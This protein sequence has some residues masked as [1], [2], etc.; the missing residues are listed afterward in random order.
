MELEGVFPAWVLW[1]IAVTTVAGASTFVIQF[2]VHQIKDSWGNGNG[3][4]NDRVI[5]NGGFVC[6]VDTGH[7]TG[8]LSECH[9]H[10]EA[11]AERDARMLSM[12]DQIIQ[13]LRGL[14]QDTRDLHSDMRV[15]KDRL[16]R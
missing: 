13:E 1:L 10:R 11:A 4:K 6:P 8:Q 5:G 7:L 14:R 9:N 3:R 12:L 2:I 15:L 16:S